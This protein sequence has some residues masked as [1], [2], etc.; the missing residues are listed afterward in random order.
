MTKPQGIGAQLE[1]DRERGQEHKIA[2]GQ[3]DPG[4][5]V[6]NPRGKTHDKSPRAVHRDTG[7]GPSTTA[8]GGCGILEADSRGVSPR[9]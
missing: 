8:T 6:A 4:L 2:H 9:A 3:D 7:R 5:E 1:D